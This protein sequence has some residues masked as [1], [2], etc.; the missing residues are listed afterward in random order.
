MSRVNLQG[1]HAHIRDVIPPDEYA[2]GDDSA[3][4]NFVAKRNLA[5]AAEAAT[6]LGQPAGPRWLDISDKTLL[7]FDE[8]LGIHPEYQG[9]HGQKIKQAD[10]VLLGFPLMMNMTAASRRADIEYYAP[11]TDI[12][13]PAM[14]WGMH[15]VGFLELGDSAQAAANFNRSFAN[16]QMPFYV[17][18]ETPSGGA[19]N[20]LTGVGGFLQTALFGLAGLRIQSTY[21]A[22]NPSLIDGITS[23]VVRGLHYHG[24]LQALIQ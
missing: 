24:A 4:T 18:T 12:N 15:T 2:E 13:G 11:R 17:W 8:K 6:I 7:L 23:I 16:A 9:Y 19:V 10:V 1:A 14:T 20:F 3:Y 21:L 5:F 22:L